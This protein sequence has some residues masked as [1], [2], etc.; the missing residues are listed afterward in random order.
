MRMKGTGCVGAGVLLAL[1]AFSMQAVAATFSTRSG[2]IVAPTAQ[3]LIQA[4]DWSCSPVTIGANSALTMSATTGYT[5]VWLT[6]GPM[7]QVTGDFS[8]IVQLA[9]PSPGAALTLIGQLGPMLF[10]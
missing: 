5:N 1:A 3:D 2:W 6:E 10:T 7:L 9:Q 4:A 8:V